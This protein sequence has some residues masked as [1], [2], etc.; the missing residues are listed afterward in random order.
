MD[1]A[2]L[3]PSAFRVCKTLVTTRLL[4]KLLSTKYCDGSVRYHIV[5]ARTSKGCPLYK[6]M[7]L[8]KEEGQEPRLLNTGGAKLSERGHVCTGAVTNT[9][10]L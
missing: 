6:E 1:L 9:V 8:R 2:A 10:S 7:K 5:E 3:L 4:R